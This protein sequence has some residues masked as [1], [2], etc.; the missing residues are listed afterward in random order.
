MQVK[1]S[2]RVSG[3]GRITCPYYDEIDAIIGNRAASQPPVLLESSGVD[4]DGGDEVETELGSV[5]HSNDQGFNCG[6]H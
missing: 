5:D 3:S 4:G 1:D 6:L 2:N